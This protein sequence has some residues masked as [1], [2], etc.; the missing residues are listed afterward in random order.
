V[1]TWLISHAKSRRAVSSLI[2]ALRLNIIN[3]N[4]EDITI[5][6]YAQKSTATDQYSLS[7]GPAKFDDAMARFEV[8]TRRAITLLIL[9][10]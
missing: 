4:K 9:V 2:S 7:Y 1:Q 3:Q 6:V 5:S 8:K 10:R